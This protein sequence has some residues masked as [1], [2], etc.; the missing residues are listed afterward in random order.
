MALYYFATTLAQTINNV[1]FVRRQA[2]EKKSKPYRAPAKADGRAL[3]YIEEKN[4]PEY[5]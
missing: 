1:K 3:A 5:T 2:A 4:I